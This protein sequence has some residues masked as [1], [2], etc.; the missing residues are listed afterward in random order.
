MTSPLLRWRRRSSQ[1]GGLDMT[2]T[3]SIS[4]DGGHGRLRRRGT[5]SGPRGWTLTCAGVDCKRGDL[6]LRLD[7]SHTA[8]DDDDTSS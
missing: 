2:D 8:M 5:G 3:C 7:A 1:D 6:N 4:G